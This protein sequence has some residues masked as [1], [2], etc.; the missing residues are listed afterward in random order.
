VALVGG[1]AVLSAVFVVAAVRLHVD[2]VQEVWTTVRRR[3]PGR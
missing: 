1:G 3:L 2:E